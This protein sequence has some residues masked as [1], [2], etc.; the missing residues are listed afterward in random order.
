MTYPGAGVSY[1][2]DNKFRLR[3]GAWEEGDPV[4]VALIAPEKDVFDLS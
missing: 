3:F 4:E 1:Q 2:Q